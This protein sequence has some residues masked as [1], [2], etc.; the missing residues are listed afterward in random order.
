MVGGLVLVPVISLV[1]PKMDKDVINKM[2][3]CYDKKVLVSVKETL[4]EEN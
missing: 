2:F 4:E 3:D 1:T